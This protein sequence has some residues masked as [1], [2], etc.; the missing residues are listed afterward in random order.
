MD[1]IKAFSEEVFMHFIE[2]LIG[3]APDGGS[4]ALEVVL[5]TVFVSLLSIGW[6]H[7]RPIESCE[8][9]NGPGYKQ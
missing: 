5:L 1:V 7:G 3:F 8:L 4:A 9:K 6:R 2:Q